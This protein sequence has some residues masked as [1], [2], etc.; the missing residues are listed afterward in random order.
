MSTNSGPG[1]GWSPKQRRDSRRPDYKSKS[2]INVGAPSERARGIARRPP[3]S[4]LRACSSLATVVLLVQR[5]NADSDELRH[6]KAWRSISAGSALGR[7]CFWGK[8]EHGPA[9]RVGAHG[10]P[11]RRGG[12]PDDRERDGPGT[13]K[14]HAS[15]RKRGPAARPIGRCFAYASART[16]IAADRLRQRSCGPRAE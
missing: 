2:P 4:R 8:D 12:P 3:S 5:D 16:C 14:E 11:G 6:R 1:C 7:A 15:R 9:D 10:T 13:V